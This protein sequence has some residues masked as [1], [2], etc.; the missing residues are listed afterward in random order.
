M[1]S[2][3][4]Q[5]LVRRRTRTVV[6]STGQFRDLVEKILKSSGRRIDMSSPFVDAIHA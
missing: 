3:E 6:Q 2:T 1:D 4:T 5:G